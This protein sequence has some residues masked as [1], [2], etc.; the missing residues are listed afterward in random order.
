MELLPV[1][2]GN[3]AVDFVQLTSAVEGAGFDGS[4]RGLK[5]YSNISMRE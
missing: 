1:E 5:G 3:D 2:E 4:L